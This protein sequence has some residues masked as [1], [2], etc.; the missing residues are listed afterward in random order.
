MSR[1][2]GHRLPFG[3]RIDREQRLSFTFNG[4]R[5]EGY[6]GDTLASALLANG[7][8][9][10]GRSFKYH[11]PRG[12]FSAGVEE[13]IALIQ[14]GS[15]PQTQPNMPATAVELSDGLV[16]NSV[17]C[18]PNVNRDI[19]ALAQWLSPFMP[20]GFYYKTFMWPARRWMVYE[21]YIRNAAGLG[22][23][24]TEADP[25]IYDK[26]HVHCDVLVIG[27]GP[28][29]LAAAL[30]AGRSGARV[31]VADQQ[32][33]FGGQLLGERLEID[34]GPAMAWVAA[35]LDEL[36]GMD[37]VGLLPRTTAFGYYDHNFV[38]LLERRPIAAAETG[39]L[40]RECLWKVR[41]KQVV[42]A[43]GAIERPLIF[44]NNDRPGVMLA[45]AARTYVNRYAVAPG[46]TV[47]VFTNN[48]DAYRTAIVLA[49]VGVKVPAL[50]DVRAFA[51]GALREQV[52][53]HGIEVLNGWS[54]INAHGGR[55]V[56]MVDVVALDE[57]GAAASGS[58]RSIDC[59]TVAVSGGWNPAVHLF[60]QS[61]GKL[62]FDNARACFVP[63][64]SVQSERSA[65]SCAGIFNLDGCLEAGFEV[66]AAAAAD[67]GFTHGARPKRPVP[68]RRRS[69]P[70]GHCCGCRHRRT[71]SASASTSSIC[72]TTSRSPTSN[73]PVMR[74]T[75]R[76]N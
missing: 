16:A 7:V 52:S 32:P 63:D 42:L 35:A 10:V 12:V 46:N 68:R 50:V 60:S 61:G 75:S 66:G 39:R 22:T 51:P 5:L 62:R 25:D 38:A 48:D 6:A 4:K 49:E 58:R 30:A 64:V 37:E 72:T 11:R 15:G 41:A 28:A 34:G 67:A 20:A 55:R 74:A 9:V 3:G 65:G 36:A 29:G 40:A 23:A 43:T 19:G 76:W 24:P 73:W 70:C 31:I 2:S 21:R 69:N 45:N 57:A 26:M 53:A 56:R 47:V 54:V 8:S 59:D 44:A 71:V 1:G 27:G 17:H 18:W 33:E 13:P 14:L